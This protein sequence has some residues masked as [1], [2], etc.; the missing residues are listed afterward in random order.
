MRFAYRHSAHQ[1]VTLTFNVCTAACRRRRHHHCRCHRLGWVRLSTVDVPA[2]PASLPAKHRPR[3]HIYIIINICFGK[4]ARWQSV[5]QSLFE[6]NERLKLQRENADI[7][8]KSQRSQEEAAR[9][10][11]R[12]GEERRKVQDAES[13]ARCVT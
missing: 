8:A 7:G 1:S 5:W 3:E 10:R 9:L 2:R 13:N 12:L 4:P 6:R 11:A